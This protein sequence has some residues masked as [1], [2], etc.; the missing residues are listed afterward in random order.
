MPNPGSVYAEIDFEKSSVEVQYT[1][2]F[3]KV[4]QFFAYV[5]GLIGT[6]LGFIFIMTAYNEL[7][8]YIS[9]ASKLFLLEKGKNISS[10]SFN[11]FKYFGYMLFKTF[12]IFGCCDGWETMKKL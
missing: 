11:L 4:D 8:Y 1:R 9:V 10:D 5:G 2:T 6:V 12:N 3:E 7:C